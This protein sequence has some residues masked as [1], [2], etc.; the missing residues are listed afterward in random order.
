MHGTNTSPNKVP[1]VFIL[2]SGVPI[3]MPMFLCVVRCQE[4]LDNSLRRTVR[5]RNGRGIIRGDVEE[6]R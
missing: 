3:I 2:A 5:R 6:E 1:L 4:W